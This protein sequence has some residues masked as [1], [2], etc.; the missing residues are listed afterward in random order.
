V[1]NAKFKIKCGEPLKI[2]KPEAVHIQAQAYPKR[3]ENCIKISLDCPFKTPRESV[4]SQ[5][6]N[7]QPVSVTGPVTRKT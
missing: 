3:S 5:S 7:F 4:F 1:I 6:R 2:K